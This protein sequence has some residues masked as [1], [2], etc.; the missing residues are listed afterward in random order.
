MQIVDEHGLP[1]RT[2]EVKVTR[3]QSV[4][5]GITPNQRDQTWYDMTKSLMADFDT[6]MTA[7][8]GGHFGGYF[9]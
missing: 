9:Q 8:I 3:S 6:Q 5:E 1:L 4:L 2:V 7:E